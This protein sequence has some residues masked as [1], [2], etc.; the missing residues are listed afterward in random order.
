MAEPITEEQMR[1][2]MR[3]KYTDHFGYARG[4]F[5]FAQEKLGKFEATADTPFKMA[6]VLITG[7]AFKSHYA[8]LN[9][10][11]I[12][13]TEDAG[14]LLRSLFNLLVI[15]RWMSYRD[16][17]P[18]ARRYLGWFWVA[19]KD[20]LKQP[21]IKVNPKMQEFIEAEYGNHKA[22][23][24]YRDRQGQLKMAKKWYEPLV[25]NLEKMAEE[26]DLKEHYEGLYRPLSS[27][28]HSD[29]LAYFG[30][31]SE[32][33]KRGDSKS[34]AMHSDLFVPV[35]LRNAFQYFGE[36]LE[37]WDRT[38]NAVPEPRLTEFLRGGVDFFKK[39]VPP[40]E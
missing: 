14:I 22:L 8:I 31:I 25:D 17:E 23:F 26:V 15:V 21:F 38:V 28:E 10:C 27:I 36:I 33:E 5:E 19:M 30:M 4:L 12:A 3:D 13:H 29:A 24:E 20:P 34:L 16:S 11:E 2:A 18:K 39:E 7:K 6:L 40:P 32:M 35:Y 37:T 1:R 9:L